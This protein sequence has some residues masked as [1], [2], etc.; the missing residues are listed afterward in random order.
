MCGDAY[1]PIF[2]PPDRVLQMAAPDEGHDCPECRVLVAT[3][4]EEVAEL[5]DKLSRKEA[6]L[7]AGGAQ[8]RKRG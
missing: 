1:N 3:L 6:G 7:N 2:P 8:P 5:R 4:R